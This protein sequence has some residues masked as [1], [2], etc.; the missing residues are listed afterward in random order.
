MD[1]K[2]IGMDGQ[3]SQILVQEMDDGKSQ[4][5]ENSDIISKQ[6]DIMKASIAHQMEW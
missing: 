4:I 2:D 6:K 1:A 5:F 3:E